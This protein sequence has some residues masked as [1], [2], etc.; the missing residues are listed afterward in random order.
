MADNATENPVNPQTLTR[1][2]FLDLS[3][4]AALGLWVGSWITACS[5]SPPPAV[6]EE[7]RLKALQELDRQKFAD[8]VNLLIPARAEISES[9]WHNDPSETNL[10][11][12]PARSVEENIMKLKDPDEKIR[13]ALRYCAL[14][15]KNPDGTFSPPRRWGRESPTLCNLYAQPVAQL[16]TYGVGAGEPLKI[17]HI[18]SKKTGQPKDLQS[19]LEVSKYPA[20]D[21]WELDA[22]MTR[23]WF[24]KHGKT[25]GWYEVKDEKN[26][27]D[28]LSKRHL[29]YGIKTY[30]DIT[31]TP[32][33]Y[34]NSHNWILLGYNSR[35]LGRMSEVI[36]QAT[37]N[38]FMARKEE[39]AASPAAL[40][41]YNP[42]R[43]PPQESGHPQVALWA[44][45][46][47]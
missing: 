26:L 32:D 4:R 3:W 15:V 10:A 19:K 43:Y 22:P 42:F 24:E 34:N 17:S 29:V 27:N 39:T 16:L 21:R 13:C 35:S 33:L 8:E 9:S 47:V 6:S 1:R 37:E 14:L 20:N 11:V 2:E 36:T 7:E 44:H 5:P 31:V 23:T 46:I 45:A 12:S 30:N 40:Y 38:I 25:Y 18:V 41:K 28:A